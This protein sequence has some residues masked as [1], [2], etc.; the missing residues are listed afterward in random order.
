MPVVI[1]EAVGAVEAVLQ[2]LAIDVPFVVALLP[3]G[4]QNVAP[5]SFSAVFLSENARTPKYEPR[6]TSTR[7]APPR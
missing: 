5:H 7:P 4:V 6:P 1:V 3:A 2:R